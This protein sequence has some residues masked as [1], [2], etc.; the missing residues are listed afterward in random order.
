MGAGRPGQH[1]PPCPHEPRAAEGPQRCCDKSPTYLLWAAGPRSEPPAE[2]AHPAGPPGGALL[3]GSV[4]AALHPMLSAATAAIAAAAAA[5]AGH[6]AGHALR[7]YST[8][9]NPTH[10][11]AGMAKAVGL[12]ARRVCCAASR[13]QCV[14]LAAAQLVVLL[15]GL[16]VRSACSVSCWGR[17]VL[18]ATCGHQTDGIMCNSIC[19]LYLRYSGELQG[20]SCGSGECQEEKHVCLQI[21][22][23]H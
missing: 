13:L 19:L 1:P 7:P 2:E 4:V 3:S 22:D 8:Y 11:P 15:V 12:R 16:G 14:L 23:L 21:S 10:V 17:S 6:P 5:A 20:S 18:G 9:P